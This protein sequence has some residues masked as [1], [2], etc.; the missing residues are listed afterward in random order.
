LSGLFS[1]KKL[2][3]FTFQPRDII[4]PS[5]RRY[6]Y[7]YD[8]AGGLSRIKL[9]GNAG[10]FTAELQT[11]LLGRV[12]LVQKMPGFNDP[13]VTYWTGDG[14]LL[15]IRFVAQKSVKFFQ[16]LNFYFRL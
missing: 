9:P 12:K 14:K 15:Q 7:E 5:G 10:S 4:L 8:Y 11:G 13:H 2:L 6:S 1:L 3:S 16:F